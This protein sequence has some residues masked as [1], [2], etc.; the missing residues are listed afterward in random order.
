MDAVINLLFNVT[1]GLIFLAYFR[2]AQFYWTPNMQQPRPEVCSWVIDSFQVPVLISV[3]MFPV[4]LG[5]WARR[6]SLHYPRLVISALPHWRS[7]C[8]DLHQQS[9]HALIES[10]NSTISII[11]DP[12]TVT[13]AENLFKIR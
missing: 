13:E 4:S 12:Y 11:G 7:C 3:W 2:N 5:V 9:S 6:I 1:I 10:H 8:F